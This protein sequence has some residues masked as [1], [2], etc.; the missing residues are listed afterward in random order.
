MRVFSSILHQIASVYYFLEMTTWK[1]LLCFLGFAFAAQSKK[2]IEVPINIGV[3]PSFHMLPNELSDGQTLMPGIALQIYAVLS[4]EVL[5]Q[6]AD[7]IPRNWRRLISP[8]QE[9]HIKPWYLTILPTT[10]LLHP[11]VHH[12]AW[13][14]TWSLFG[15]ESNVRP[16]KSTELQ[17]HLQLPTISATWIQSSRMEQGDKTFVGLGVTPGIQALWKPFK[18]LQFSLGWDESLYLPISTTEYTP[19]DKTPTHWIAHGIATFLVHVRI[20]TLQKI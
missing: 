6:N 5:Q 13:G 2:D 11:G 12:Q 7:R 1:F 4:P 18:S 10:I 19:I 14:V 8:D 16:T 9:L 17:A 3:G 20:P 15:L